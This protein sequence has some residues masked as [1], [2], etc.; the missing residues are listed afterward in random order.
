MLE[1]QNELVSTR[2]VRASLG[3]IWRNTFRCL[4]KSSLWK[5]FLIPFGGL[6]WIG[7]NMPNLS[8]SFWTH[9]QSDR[10]HIIN[11][12]F[13]QKSR[14]YSHCLIAKLIIGLP[15]KT[16]IAVFWAMLASSLT[17]QNPHCFI[18]K[19]TITFAHTY[20]AFAPYDLIK[21]RNM[22]LSSRVDTDCVGCHFSH[23]VIEI[24]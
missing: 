22:T 2:C 23:A 14:Q 24:W 11:N 9:G 15:K 18:G 8:K 4:L 20:E 17:C 16:R 21:I 6:C 1:G 5:P 7:Q 3:Q 13:F 10:R 19:M 12:A